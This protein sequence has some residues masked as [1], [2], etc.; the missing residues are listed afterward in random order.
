MSSNQLKHKLATYHATA[1]LT[2]NS[3]NLSST[4][5]SHPLP[6]TKQRLIS[7]SQKESLVQGNLYVHKK[8]V[9]A[10]QYSPNKSITGFKSTGSSYNII[11]FTC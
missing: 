9:L 2:G 5:G 11:H 10:D 3:K 4:K 8:I 6:N 7:L 1:Q